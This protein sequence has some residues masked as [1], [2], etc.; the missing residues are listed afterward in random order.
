LEESLGVLR[1]GR[2][3]SST[4]ST[5]FLIKWPEHLGGEATHI[6]LEGSMQIIPMMGMV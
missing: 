1:E 2:S 6:T 5:T 4:Y 3:V